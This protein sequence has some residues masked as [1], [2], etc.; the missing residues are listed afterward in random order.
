MDVD[1]V[2]AGIDDIFGD[3][4]VDP[5]TTAERLKEIRDHIDTCLDALR[6][7]GVDC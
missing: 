4:T 7:D 1:E 2:K 3:T 5:E 6:D